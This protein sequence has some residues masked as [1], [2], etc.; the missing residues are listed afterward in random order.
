MSEQ[1]KKRQRLCDLLNT[2]TKPKFLYQPYTKQ[3]KLFFF[4]TERA[5]LRKEGVESWTKSEKK[6]F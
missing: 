3:R 5:F 2:E 6:A 1:E 4:F